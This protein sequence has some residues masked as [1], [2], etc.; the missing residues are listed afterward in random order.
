MFV[1]LKYNPKGK[2]WDYPG[3]ENSIDTLRKNYGDEVAERYA[4]L[5]WEDI[6]IKLSDGVYE[7]YDVNNPIF[8]NI[9]FKTHEYVPSELAKELHYGWLNMYGDKKD[10]YMSHPYGVCDNWEQIFERVPELK[11]YKESKENFVIFLCE[12]NKKNQPERGGWRWHKWGEYIGDQ[13][14]QCEYLHDE[15]EIE[16]VYSFHIS[17]IIKRERK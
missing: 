6:L 16:R 4:N 11:Y 10:V 14:P 9:V 17:R 13:N 1:N 7:Y 2:V 3:V 5:K 8:D 15:P 12:H